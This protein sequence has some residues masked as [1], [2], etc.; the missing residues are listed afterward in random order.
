MTGESDKLEHR[1]AGGVIMAL[2]MTMMIGVGY[3][4]GYLHATSMSDN[5][6]PGFMLG[7]TATAAFAIP[8]IYVLKNGVPSRIAKVIP[9][10]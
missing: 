3:I 7:F 5:A 8:A 6:A 9:D 1:I 4:T 10:A 2:L